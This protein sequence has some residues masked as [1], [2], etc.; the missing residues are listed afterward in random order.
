MDQIRLAVS[1]LLI[2]GASHCCQFAVSILHFER[3]LIIFLYLSI[4][5]GSDCPKKLFGLFFLNVIM[6]GRCMDR[7][8]IG[9]NIF[10]DL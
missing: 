7:F 5:T 4:W 8:L 6:H 2:G 3:A 1:C 9:C 10:E